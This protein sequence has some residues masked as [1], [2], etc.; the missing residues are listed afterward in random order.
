[1]CVLGVRGLMDVLIGCRPTIHRNTE[2]RGR[3]SDSGGI[4]D[5]DTILPKLLRARVD[6]WR[7][8]MTT[9]EYED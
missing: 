6:F 4:T 3:G 1:M 8:N 7:L 2:T 5:V 9:P